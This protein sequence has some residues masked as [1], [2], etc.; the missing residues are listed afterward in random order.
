MASTSSFL[1]GAPGTE[2]E[3]K[4]GGREHGEAMRLEITAPEREEGTDDFPFEDY[5]YGI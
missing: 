2:K 1:G 3:K 5:V 4:G